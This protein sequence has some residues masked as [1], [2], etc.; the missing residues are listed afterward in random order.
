MLKPTDSSIQHTHQ[1]ADVHWVAMAKREA[2]AC[3]IH[4]DDRTAVRL[5]KQLQRLY[6]AVQNEIK[7][8]EFLQPPSPRS[9]EFM[10]ALR[11]LAP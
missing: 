1:Q 11:D 4:L 5:A 8:G 6:P 10:R 9:L 2:S 7:A 3:G